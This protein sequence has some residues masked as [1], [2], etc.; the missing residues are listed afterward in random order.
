MDEREMYK[1]L[2][3]WQMARISW[4]VLTDIKKAILLE[5]LISHGIPGA[6]AYEMVKNK[7]L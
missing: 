7:K 4:W 5:R 2:N 6:E 3:W 1:E